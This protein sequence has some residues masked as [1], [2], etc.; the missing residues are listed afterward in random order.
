MEQSMG[1]GGFGTLAY[2][3]NFRLSSRV[4]SGIDQQRGTGRMVDRS[5]NE[6]LFAVTVVVRP[7]ND[8][9]KSRDLD[10]CSC[11]HS[12]NGGNFRQA[13]LVPTKRFFR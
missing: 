12:P 9:E 7:D 8:V 2:C 1:A 5:R 3:D 4:A 6:F 13:S 11:L 10:G